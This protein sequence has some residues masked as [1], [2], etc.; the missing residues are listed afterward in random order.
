MWTRR[1][2]S[3]R[4]ASFAPPRSTIT[5]R[6]LDWLHTL[7]VVPSDPLPPARPQGLQHRLLG[8]PTPG[9]VLRGLLAVAAIAGLVG[10][11]DPIDEQFSVP[12]D[13]LGD[14]EAFGNVGA[15]S[16]DVAWEGSGFRVRI[17]A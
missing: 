2:P 10:G 12:L 4:A 11:V 8:R 17:V 15:D 1:I 7:N 9:E 6:P 3:C 5:G 16:E 13:H 14:A